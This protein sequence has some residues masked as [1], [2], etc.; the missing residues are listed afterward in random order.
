MTKRIWKIAGI[1]AGVF[2]LGILL[3]V[4]FFSPGPILVPSRPCANPP[5]V[6]AVFS[7]E[8]TEFVF[9]PK[10]IRV[11]PCQRIRLTFRNTGDD[12]HRFKIDSVADTGDIH[13]GVMRTI[14]FR[15][16]ERKGTYPF[17]DPTSNYRQIGMEGQLIVE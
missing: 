17:Y 2:L 3:L 10:E 14:E 9:R 6:T 8:G 4:I 16:P 7:I 1:S 13:P 11:Q 12:S 5:V 15:A